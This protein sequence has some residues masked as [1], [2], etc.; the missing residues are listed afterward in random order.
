MTPQER[1][2]WV[3]SFAERD[4]QDGADCEAARWELVAFNSTPRPVQ[5]APSE[6][7]YVLMG[8]PLEPYLSAPEDVRRIHAQLRES[9]K[10]LRIRRRFTLPFSVKNAAW[11]SAATL[12]P[13][14]PGTLAKILTPPSSRCFESSERAC[15]SAE[16]QPVLASSSRSVRTRL[17]AVHAAPNA[18]APR[19]FGRGMTK[20]GRGRMRVRV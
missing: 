11:L 3:L 4:L 13:F 6:A 16:H 5:A 7:D 9:L 15:G 17:S 20:A 14:Q 8:A 19:G 1:M 2:S 18:C 12:C 10:D